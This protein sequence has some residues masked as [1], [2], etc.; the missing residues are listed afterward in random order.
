[1][2]SRLLR[3]EVG[4]G[5]GGGERRL[6]RRLQDKGDFMGARTV[7]LPLIC[8]KLDN[9]SLIHTIPVLP[10]PPQDR[11]TINLDQILLLHPFHVTRLTG[12]RST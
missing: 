8:G 6:E 12:F 4:G 5:G 2:I 10:T 1:M 9:V 3:E 11:L 7:L